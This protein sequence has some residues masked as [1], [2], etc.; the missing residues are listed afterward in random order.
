MF[1]FSRRR[2]RMMCGTFAVLVLVL[3]VGAIRRRPKQSPE[4]S[5]VLLTDSSA[6]VVV[7]R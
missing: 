4:Q 3:I 7:G 5:Q 1:T 6:R 2:S